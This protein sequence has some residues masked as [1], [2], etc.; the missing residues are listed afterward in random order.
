MTRS[1][2]ESGGR[3]V[4]YAGN[5]TNAKINCL[6]NLLIT[7]VFFNCNLNSR[8]Q[9]KHTLAKVLAFC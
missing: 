5:E 6:R 3:S 9:P 1:Q 2:E 8:T 7:N 4:N